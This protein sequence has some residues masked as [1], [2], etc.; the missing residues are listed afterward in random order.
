MLPDDGT[1]KLLTWCLIGAVILAVAMMGLLCSKLERAEARA[2]EARREDMRRR[3][4]RMTTY[5]PE[6]IHRDCTVVV[7]LDSETGETVTQWF[8]ND[9]KEE[10]SL[11]DGR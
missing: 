8:P 9:P 3:V 2:N 10:A 6:E 5:D 4:P 1:G 7:W 11:W